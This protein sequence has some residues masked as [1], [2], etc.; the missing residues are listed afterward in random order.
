[1][2][3]APPSAIGRE[4]E[5]AVAWTLPFGARSTDRD[6]ATQESPRSIA[7][8]DA[9]AAMIDPLA[10]AAAGRKIA[11]RKATIRLISPNSA[12]NKAESHE[13][14]SEMQNSA[15]NL[16]VIFPVC[17]DHL[18]RS[19]SILPPEEANWTGHSHISRS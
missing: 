10:R 2:E 11:A 1:M 4:G 6:S 5:S 9:R 18:A 8:Q 19:S 12:L 15:A 14:I 16:V 13:L 3:L 17:H 7:A